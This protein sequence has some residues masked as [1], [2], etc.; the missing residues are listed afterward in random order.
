M[1]RSKMLS[2]SNH[3]IAKTAILVSGFTFLGTQHLSNYV[4]LHII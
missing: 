3:W 2:Y 1:E 4:V